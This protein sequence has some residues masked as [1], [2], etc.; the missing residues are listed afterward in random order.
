MDLYREHLTHHYRHSPHRGT[1]DSPSLTGGQYNPAC[2]DAI[3]LTGVVHDNRV[4]CLKFTGTGCVISQAAASLLCQAVAGKTVAELAH[5]GS[6]EMLTMLGVSLGPTRLK[7]ALLPLEALRT[8]LAHYQEPDAKDNDA[9]SCH[10]TVSD[11]AH[12]P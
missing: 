2:G 4:H 3:A 1:I 8:G 5:Y 9:Q 7:C 10:L 11:P 12:R 6:T